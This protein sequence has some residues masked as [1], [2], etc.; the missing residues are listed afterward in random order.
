MRNTVH[1]LRGSVTI[2]AAVIVPL[3]L[4]IF[5]LIMTI[6]FYY[7]DKNVVAAI[8][9]ETVVMGCGQEETTEAELE[10][11]FQKRMQDK[12]LLFSAIYAKT[13]VEEGKIT[14][15]CKGQKNKMLLQVQMRMSKTEPESYVRNLQKADRIKD[16]LEEQLEDK[17]ET[18]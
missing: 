14:I 6:I 4:M 5:G 9:H 16:Q 8:A 1:K 2:E 17:G 10:Q 18:E 12:L 11:Y 15:T 7:H 3:I 13:E